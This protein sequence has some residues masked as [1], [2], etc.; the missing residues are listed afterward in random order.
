MK[1]VLAAGILRG[2]NLANMHPYAFQGRM[3]GLPT[4]QR[5]YLSNLSMLS[6]LA[7]SMGYLVSF[8]KNRGK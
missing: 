2:G 3:Q 6:S 1:P 4:H 7:R 5:K 8:L